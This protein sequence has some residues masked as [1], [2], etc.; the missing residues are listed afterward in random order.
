M[1]FN[2]LIDNI[3][4]EEFVMKKFLSLALAAMI[5]LTGAFALAE[6]AEEAQIWYLLSVGM[7]GVEVSV[8]DAGSE[9]TMTLNPDGTGKIVINS[10]QQTQEN[11][12]TYSWKDNSLVIVSEGTEVTVTPDEKGHL[13]INIGTSSLTFTKDQAEVATAPS[14][15]KVTHAY[16]FINA[17]GQAVVSIKLGKSGE[18]QMSEILKEQLPDGATYNLTMTLPESIA[19]TLTLAMDYETETGI[20]GHVD[21]IPFDD[22]DIRLFLEKKE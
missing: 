22:M 4:Q 15:E 1:S 7:N 10:N 19:Q 12:F 20:V 5:I 9:G 14:G 6:Q 3:L 21:N 17:T 2:D 18:A 11:A 8:A 16:S 13:V